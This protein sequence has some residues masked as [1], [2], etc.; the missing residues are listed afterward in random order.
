[1]HALS[2]PERFL[3]LPRVHGIAD[4]FCGD[5]VSGDQWTAILTDSGT[6]VISDQA[7][8]VLVLTPS[9]GTVADNDEALLK[10]SKE[11]FLFANNKPIEFIA[12]VAWAEANTD[13]ANVMVGMMNAVAANSLQDDGAGPAASYS[14]FNF[15][16]L[17]GGTKWIFE[18]SLAGTQTT[19]TL[20]DTAPTSATGWHSLKVAVRSRGSTVLEV[21]PYIDT[22]GG[23]NFVQCVDANGLKVKHTI[24]L[25]SPTEMQIVAAVKNGGANNEALQIDYLAAYQLR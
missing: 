7:G 24:T 21:I 10:S 11:T 23:Q 13:D 20:G 17:D 6:A 22:A 2:V 14:G 12:R 15:H 4:D 25:G 18:S 8:G 9:D 16:K 1:M 19:T 5:Y 3:L